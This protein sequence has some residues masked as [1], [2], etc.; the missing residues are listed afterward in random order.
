M[1]DKKHNGRGARW[2][3]NG[4]EDCSTESYQMSVTMTTVTITTVNMYY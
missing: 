3:V 2:I 4:L 1:S